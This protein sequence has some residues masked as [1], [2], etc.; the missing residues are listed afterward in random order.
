[1]RRD[2]NDVLR[3]AINFSVLKKKS[4]SNRKRRGEGKLI[5]GIKKKINM[6][7]IGKKHAINRKKW[8]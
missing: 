4:E 5:K 8:G 2:S 1:M 6:E 3:R 7:S